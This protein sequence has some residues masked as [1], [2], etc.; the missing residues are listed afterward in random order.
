MVIIQRNNVRPGVRME[1]VTIEELELCLVT[2]D[3]DDD[4][5]IMKS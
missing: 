1:D 5:W 2:I 4:D 3:D